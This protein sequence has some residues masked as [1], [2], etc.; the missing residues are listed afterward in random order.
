MCGFVQSKIKERGKVME[1][2]LPVPVVN[3]IG[4]PYLPT[5][6]EY[7]TLVQFIL[8]HEAIEPSWVRSITANDQSEKPTTFV[9]CGYFLNNKSDPFELTFRTNDH[10][11][12]AKL[13]RAQAG[14]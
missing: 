9:V 8:C 3:Q 10:V 6:E 7:R 1:K 11:Y 5:E 14:V 12:L 4:V 2:K 13:T